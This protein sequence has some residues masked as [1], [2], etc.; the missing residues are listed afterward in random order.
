MREEYAKQNIILE[1]K[2]KI[3]ITLHLKGHSVDI[4]HLN[5]FNFFLSNLYQ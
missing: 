2:P 3:N 1:I 4:N 5:A